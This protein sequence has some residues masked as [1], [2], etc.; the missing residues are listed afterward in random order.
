M[1]PSNSTKF[2]QKTIVSLFAGAGGV[3]LG[4]KQAGHDLLWANDIDNDSCITYQ[5]NLHSKIECCDIRT[6][7]NSV[8]PEADVIVGGFPC[9]GFSVAN[10][11]RSISD[12]RNTMYLEM[13]RIVEEKLPRWFIA[14][15]VPGILSLNDGEVFQQIIEDFSGIGYRVTYALQNMADF[16]IPQ[17]RRRVII[18]GTR[19]DLSPS[20][21]LRHPTPTHSKTGTDGKKMWVSI[22]QAL[23]GLK[24]PQHSSDAQSQ[25][26]F[27]ERN[28]VG[29]RKTN[30]DLPSPTILA[31]GNGKGGVNALP[32]PFEPRRLSVLESACIQG[33]P[34]DFTFAGSMTSRYRQ[35]GN[36]I[37]PPYGKLLGM[38]LGSIYPESQNLEVPAV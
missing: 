29:H 21:D 3:D 10:K 32:H 27:V 13:R 35:I 23:A 5:S 30:P 24:T 36:A 26:K 33:F 37:P 1:K 14:E 38:Q 18:L 25:Y 20:L 19:N 9:Q 2:A 4:L 28:F 17:R 11:F 22:S 8:I 15:N 7:P 16:G 31:R 34:P 12:S 6:I